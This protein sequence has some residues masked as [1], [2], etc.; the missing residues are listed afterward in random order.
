MRSIKTKKKVI[1]E[2]KKIIDY[3][4]L[5]IIIIS[6]E[7]AIYGLDESFGYFRTERFFF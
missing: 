5:K 7:A 6:I 4:L 3:Q 1:R 2:E